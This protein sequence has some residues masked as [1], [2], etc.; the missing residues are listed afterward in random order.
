[1]IAD[2]GQ[3]NSVEVDT[4]FLR[5]KRAMLKGGEMVTL[6]VALVSFALGSRPR[7]ITASVLEIVI[8]SLLLMLYLLKLNKRLTLFFWPFVDFFNSV[9]AAV[10]LVVLGLMALT[11][12]SYAGT[13]AGGIAF[14]VAALLFFIDSYMLFRNVTLNKPRNEAQQQG[15]G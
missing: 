5:T 1:M 10:Y 7:F 9:F 14:F 13:L 2:Q 4:A 15:S 8:T 3:S 6:C 11:T 12:Y